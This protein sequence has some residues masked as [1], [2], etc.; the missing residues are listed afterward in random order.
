MSYQIRQSDDKSFYYLLE[1][2]ENNNQT[3]LLQDEDL[4]KVR[5]HEAVKGL[6]LQPVPE[7]ETRGII[8]E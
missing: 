8:T 4:E 2:D 3:V 1:I 5:A 6:D 7:H